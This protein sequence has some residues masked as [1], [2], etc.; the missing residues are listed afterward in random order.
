MEANTS[1]CEMHDDRFNRGEKRMDKIEDNTTKLDKKV[2]EIEITLSAWKVYLTIGIA[3]FA[4]IGT[5]IA[6]KTMDAITEATKA[7]NAK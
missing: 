7:K 4:L 2:Q 6:N 5:F 3:V 1:R